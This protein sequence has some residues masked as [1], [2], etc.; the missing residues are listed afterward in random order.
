MP[1]CS[2]RRSPSANE[3]GMMEPPPLTVV[4]MPHH[5]KAI[6]SKIINP[7]ERRFVGYECVAGSDDRLFF[8]ISRAIRE[9]VW[10]SKA[11]ISCARRPPLDSP[12]VGSSKLSCR[13][14]QPHAHREIFRRKAE[15][16]CSLHL[17]IWAQAPEKFGFQSSR[18]GMAERVGFEPTVR[19]PAHTLSKRAP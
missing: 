1:S 15:S 18:L 6:G 9:C 3:T 5:V 2:M 11:T 17:E 4:P 16:S 13:S 19:F 12:Y 10:T 7:R 14:D 8:G